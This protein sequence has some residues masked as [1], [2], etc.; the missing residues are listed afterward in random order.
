MEN[1][2]S[3]QQGSHA[4]EP[5][6]QSRFCYRFA[7]LVTGF[8]SKV[9]FRRKF[10][11]NEIK[12]KKG[13]FV[14]IANHQAAYDFVNLMSATSE[15]MH[16]VIS[17]SFYNT[18][19]IK[20]FLTKLGVIPKQQFQTA[21]RDL[22]LMKQ[23]IADGK[24]LVIYP[25]GLMCEDGLSTPIPEAT[26]QFLKWIKADVYMAKTKGTYF[27]MPK[28]SKGLRRGRTFLDVYKLFSKE[29]L[30]ELDLNDVKKKT[31]EALLFDAYREQE[32]LLVKYKRGSDIEGLENVLYICPSCGSEHVMHVRDKRVIYC[33][34]CGFAEESDKYGFLHKI[35]EVGKE[36]RY[37][38]DWSRY[39]HNRVTKILDDEADIEM[40]CRA[41]IRMIDDGRHRF[42]DVGTG[43]VTLTKEQFTI[44]GRIKGEPLFVS[45]PTANFASLP[46]S[47]ANYFEI[48]HN[49]DI[50]RCIPDNPDRV[51]EYVHTVKVLY[52]KH[53]A[54]CEK[55]RIA[56]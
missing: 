47:P 38:S 4:V 27:A 15:P 50:Y 54:A 51:M 24:I 56:E 26:Y 29:E 22:R 7:R 30:S 28:W 39:I 41:K 32:E 43:I 44:E 18:L 13:P 46:F 14:V 48:Q 45:V 21:I 16:F 11:R 37:V 9:F 36:I 10:I 49:A 17:E 1:K 3:E 33:D 53:N 19:P 5:P 8:V 2:N 6:K 20:G 52:E 31:E 42:T 12:G 55:V 35:S 25:A 23:V 34:K 40:S